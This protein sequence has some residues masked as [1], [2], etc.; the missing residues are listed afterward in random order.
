MCGLECGRTTAIVHHIHNKIRIRL[1]HPPTPP[2]KKRKLS[3]NTRRGPLR[4]P[5]FYSLLPQSSYSIRVAP[6]TSRRGRGGRR[7]RKKKNRRRRKS[8]RFFYS[9]NQSMMSVLS[10]SPRWGIA[11]LPSLLL[12]D[13]VLLFFFLLNFT[14]LWWILLILAGLYWVCGSLT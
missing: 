13:W 1:P 14:G 8:H 5:C 10:G 11:L 2:K 4:C 12:I 7:K 9:V 3:R 6:S